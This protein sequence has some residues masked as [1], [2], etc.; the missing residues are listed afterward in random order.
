MTEAKEINAPLPV[1]H[2]LPVLDRAARKLATVPGPIWSSYDSG[3]V[4][5]VFVLK[6]KT[7]IEQGRM[8]CAQKRELWGL[9]AP[10]CDWDDVAR[11]YETGNQLFSLIETLYWQ[12]IKEP[13]D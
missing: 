8:T 7:D 11:D 4:I 13:G 12:E 1:L 5:A 6:W 10:T 2:L 3:V 9:F